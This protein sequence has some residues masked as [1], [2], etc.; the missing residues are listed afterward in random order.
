MSADPAANLRG[1][2]E[3]QLKDA[4]A[5]P[6]ASRFTPTLVADHPFADP[7]LEELLYAFLAWE[8]GDKKAAPAPAKLAATCVDA[9][10][11]RICLSSEIVAALGSTYP[12]AAERAE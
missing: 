4:P 7:I 3:A 9:N 11:L 12:K 2:L 10:E 5:A 6:E 1:L 8:A